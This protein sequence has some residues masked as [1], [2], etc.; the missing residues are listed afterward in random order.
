MGEIAPV[1]LVSLGVA[2]PPLRAGGIPVM[3]P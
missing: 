3:G 1:Q 2:S